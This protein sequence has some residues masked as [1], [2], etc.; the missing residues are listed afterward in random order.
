M[1]INK[2]KLGYKKIL[3]H[4]ETKNQIILFAIDTKKNHLQLFENFNQN[5]AKTSFFRF[6][7]FS[8]KEN[9]KNSIKI[10]LI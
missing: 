3:N 7:F 6:S 4:K 8:G 9:P 5:F 2:I 1:K 10:F